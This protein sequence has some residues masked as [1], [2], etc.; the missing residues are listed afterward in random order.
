VGGGYTGIR[1][2]SYSSKYDHKGR[3]T[4]PDKLSGRYEVTPNQIRSSQYAIAG[5]VVDLIR[6]IDLSLREMYLP[7]LH[8]KFKNNSVGMQSGVHPGAQEAKTIKRGFEWQSM[9][10]EIH[11]SIEKIDKDMRDI[12]AKKDESMKPAKSFD[13]YCTVREVEK[14]AESELATGSE[15]KELNAFTFAKLTKALDLVTKLIDAP[16]TPRRSLDRASQ[17]DWTNFARL[18]A[19]RRA[20]VEASYRRYRIG[21]IDPPPR[22]HTAKFDYD[23]AEIPR[24][25]SGTSTQPIAY[26]KRFDLKRAYDDEL[27]MLRAEACEVCSPKNGKSVSKGTNTLPNPY[28]CDRQDVPDY[29][30]ANREVERD[31]FV[32]KLVT[33]KNMHRECSTLTPGTNV[34]VCYYGVHFPGI[35]LQRNVGNGTFKVQFD[36]GTINDFPVHAIIPSSCL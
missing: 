30:Y 34:Q 7:Q 25:E 6:L 36:D 10:K 14:W 27:E 18:E 9:I 15:K 20:F 24:G 31:S 28:T 32:S 3:R 35:I 23:V 8:E 5:H 1:I 16:P 12:E 13:P 33:S 17:N 29:S 22:P 21:P 26:P 2:S 4:D 11:R 19:E